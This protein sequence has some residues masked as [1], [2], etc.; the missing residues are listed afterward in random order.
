MS[1][2]LKNTTFLYFRM[3]VVLVVSLYTS[4]VILDSLGIVDYGIYNL[5]SGIVVSFSFITTTMSNTSMRYYSIELGRR[6]KDALTR[7]FNINFQL[8]TLLSVVFII[9]VEVVGIYMLNNVLDIPINRLN[10]AKILLQFSIFICVLQII[11]TPFVSAMIATE[12]MSIYGYIGIV[13]AIGKL[14]IS[15]LLLYAV[16]DRLI[17]YGGSLLVMHLI[18]FLIY[19][20]YSC[21]KIDFCEFRRVKDIP[22]LKNIVNF[23]GWSLLESLADI[24]SIQGINVLLNV[25][26]GIVVNA[27]AGVANQVSSLV[28]SFI[29]NFQTA[30]K[31]QITKYYAQGDKASY[32]RL[33]LQSSKLSFFLYFILALP[34]FINLPK[35]FELWLVEVPT[36]SIGIARIV[37]INLILGTLA[38]PIHV[39]VQAKGQVKKYQIHVTSIMLLNFPL[40]YIVLR[41]G[42]SPYWVFAVRGFVSLLAHISRILFLRKEIGVS[43]SMYLRKVI[44]PMLLS[45]IV[46]LIPTC[47]IYMMTDGYAQLILSSLSSI[48]FSSGI[49]FLLGLEDYEKVYVKSIIKNFIHA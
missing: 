21:K 31:P 8:Y 1:K 42:F 32:T 36:Y 16:S 47:V 41:Y 45:A 44:S 11:Q 46:T 35:L 49:F 27:A 13:E 6:N 38:V 29:S 4:R 17:L 39:L 43:S 48:L 5:V 18:I 15:F 24:F 14:F 34:L 25:F 28:W 37:L 20:V 23:S 30:F 10:T 22:L 3:I 19:Y 40:A 9:I 33:M 12:K 26:I 7:L 2:I